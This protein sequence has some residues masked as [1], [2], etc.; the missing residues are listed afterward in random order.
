MSRLD[1]HIRQKIAQRDS[2]NLA[3]QWLAGAHGVI[4]EFGLIWL[5]HWFLG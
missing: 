2:I 3:A 5:S 1:S 4:L